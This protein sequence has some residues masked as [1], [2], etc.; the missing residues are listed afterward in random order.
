MLLHFLCEFVCVCVCV[1]VYERQRTT[2]RKREVK[3]LPIVELP[4]L[5][6]NSC[7]KIFRFI[8]RIFKADSCNL[9]YTPC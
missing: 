9:S 3:C 7:N 4:R 1:C 5:L 8:S 2:D 6:A